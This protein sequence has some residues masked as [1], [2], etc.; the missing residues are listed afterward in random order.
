MSRVGRKIITIPKGVKVQ[1]GNGQLLVEGPK[2]KLQSP[3]PPGISF[4]LEG[5]ELQAS[6]GH[7]RVGPTLTRCCRAPRRRR[8]S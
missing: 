6:R 1:I 7:E 4:K 2:G 3:V 5:S 8:P